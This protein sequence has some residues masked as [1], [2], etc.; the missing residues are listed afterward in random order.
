MFSLSVR[1]ELFTIRKGSI[2]AFEVACLHALVFVLLFLQ[3]GDVQARVSLP[4]CLSVDIDDLTP[5]QIFPTGFTQHVFAVNILCGVSQIGKNTSR[6][7][8]V[9]VRVGNQGSNTGVAFDRV[10][11]IEIVAKILSRCIS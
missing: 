10:D 11:I 9:E 5:F 3:L 1:C 4:E 7:P 8:G 2:A 6:L